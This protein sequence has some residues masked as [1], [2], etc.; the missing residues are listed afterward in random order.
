MATFARIFFDDV[1]KEMAQLTLIQQLEFLR[2]GQPMV[3]GSLA[4]FR[5]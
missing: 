2:Y 1:D 3:F 4:N 5:V